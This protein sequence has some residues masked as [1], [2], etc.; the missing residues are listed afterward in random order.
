M[1][2]LTSPTLT[3]SELAD[4]REAS[5]QVRNGISALVRSNVVTTL[6]DP[7]AQE[8]LEGIVAHASLACDLLDMHSRGTYRATMV[9]QIKAG[10]SILQVAQEELQ[11]LRIFGMESDDPAQLTLEAFKQ[12]LFASALVSSI[13]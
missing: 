9:P 7:D 2:D 10:R 12:A 3:H 4:V 5:S 1:N 8:A 6:G 13:H 11:D